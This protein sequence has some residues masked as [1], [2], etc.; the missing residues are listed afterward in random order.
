MLN[1]G[2][3]NYSLISRGVNIEGTY[4]PERIFYIFE[5]ELYI[6]EIEVIRE[7][8]QWVSEHEEIRRFGSGN[9]E[10]RFKQF[11]EANRYCLYDGG[12]CD[13]PTDSMAKCAYCGRG[14]YR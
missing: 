2:E 12:K 11:L 13:Y 1:L 14:S 5:E 7:F 9:Y 4:D 10:E 3:R 8:L 6:D